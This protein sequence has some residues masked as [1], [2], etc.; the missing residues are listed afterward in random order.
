MGLGLLQPH[1]RVHQAFMLWGWA[2]AEEQLVLKEALLLLSKSH[3][4]PPLLFIR[5][6]QM[7]ADSQSLFLWLTRAALQKWGFLL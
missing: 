3:L 5:T 6:A 1:L 7:E 2:G 4:S